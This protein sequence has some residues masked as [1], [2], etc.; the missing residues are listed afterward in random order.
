[1][2]DYEVENVL[3]NYSK[4]TLL[5]YQDAKFLANMY[6][7]LEV[8]LPHLLVSQHVI[9]CDCDQFILPKYIL[10]LKRLHPHDNTI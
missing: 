9:L 1:M 4:Y 7:P 6:R 8:T 2:Y 5:L 3:W 10:C